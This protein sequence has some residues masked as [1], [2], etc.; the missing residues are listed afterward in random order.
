[1]GGLWWICWLDMGYVGELPDVLACALTRFLPSHWFIHTIL[2]AVGGLC[3]NT[4]RLWLHTEQETLITSNRW[5][6][7]FSRKSGLIFFSAHR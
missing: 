3:L 2:L 6:A 5:Q 1:M 7:D 4:V